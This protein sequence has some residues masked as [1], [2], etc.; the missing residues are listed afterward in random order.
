[1]YV[2]TCTRVPAGT[3]WLNPPLP[4]AEDGSLYGAEPA[5]ADEAA[6]AID[7]DPPTRR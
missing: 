7:I 3:F 1:M 2:L 6:V 4:M 5:P